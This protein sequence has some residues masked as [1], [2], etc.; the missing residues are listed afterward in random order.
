MPSGAPRHRGGG[1]RRG[2]RCQRQVGELGGR[3]THRRAGSAAAY[4]RRM[5]SWATILFPVSLRRYPLM[6]AV[7]HC[8]AHDVR[9]PSHPV[10]P[11]AESLTR[12]AAK[13]V[14]TLLSSCMLEAIFRAAR[15]RNVKKLKC[16]MQ[17][18]EPKTICKHR[19][20]NVCMVPGIY[21]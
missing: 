20:I 16:R 14:F 17:W 9:G 12:I 11:P 21:I 6:G 5:N 4:L 13:F 1:Q 2:T 15:R 7:C 3:R 19:T 10:S 8:C 18:L